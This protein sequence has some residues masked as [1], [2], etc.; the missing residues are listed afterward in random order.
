MSTKAIKSSKTDF[1]KVLDFTDYHK[2][3]NNC[4]KCNSYEEVYLKMDG[5]TKYHTCGYVW[6]NCKDKSVKDGSWKECTG[7]HSQIF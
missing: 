6:H 5:K 4:P 7:D 2:K 1:T 3:F